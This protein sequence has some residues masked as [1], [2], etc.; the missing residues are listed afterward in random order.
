MTTGK[1]LRLERFTAD[2]SI[3]TVAAEMDLSRQALWAL[4]RTAIVREE[5]ASAYRRAIAAIL[6]RRAQ[7]GVD[8]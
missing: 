4:E 2:I 8:R 3:R 5:R 7:E 6:E 1:Q